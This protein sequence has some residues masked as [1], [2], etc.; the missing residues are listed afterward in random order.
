[1]EGAPSFVAAGFTPAILLSPFLFSAC[2]PER[3]RGTSL[4]LALALAVA[5]AVAVPL[6][7]PC[8]A[9][10]VAPSSPPF[11]ATGFSPVIF[12]L[13]LPLPLPLR[14]HPEGGQ[15]DEGS[16]FSF[17]TRAAQ[18]DR[19][20]PRASAGAQHFHFEWLLL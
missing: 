5:V 15:P 12:G 10:A 6:P 1:M 9:V 3:S 19:R 13:L 8:R 11:V 16:A 18:L 14:R 17:L 4:A 7:L 2:H 20:N